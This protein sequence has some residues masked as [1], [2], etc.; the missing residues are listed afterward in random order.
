MG[1]AN[2][3]GCEPMKRSIVKMAASMLVGVIL[4]IQDIPANARTPPNALRDVDSIAM[5]VPLWTNANNIS[6][7]VTSSSGKANCFGL[8]DAATGTTSIKATFKLERK[9]GLS[10]EHEKT[11]SKESS[12]KTLTFSDKTRSVMAGHTYRLSVVAVVVTNGVSETVSSSSESK[13]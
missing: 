1:P 7:S 10:W 9:N 12:T 13:L 8:I 5:I 2:V 6:L 4:L 11:W 3:K